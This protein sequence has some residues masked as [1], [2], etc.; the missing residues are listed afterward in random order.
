MKQKK[1]TGVTLLEVLIALFVL[2]VG[3]LGMAGLQLTGL[4]NS[5]S[6]QNRTE[7]ALQANNILERM[8]LNQAV[9]KAG[10][11]D[12]DLADSAP[13]GPELVNQDLSEW[14]DNLASNLPSGDGQIETDAGTGVIVITIQ[15]DD[16]RGTSG[17]ATQSFAMGS[18]L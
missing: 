7:A 9:A 10:G 1:N 15:W 3:L 11:Y 14:L 18:I 5:Y 13:G 17:S 8:R 6:A 16:S 2:S 12:I 4:K